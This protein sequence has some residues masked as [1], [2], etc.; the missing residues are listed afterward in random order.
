MGIS[1]EIA[2]IFDLV[3]ACRYVEKMTKTFAL[4]CVFFTWS[5]KNVFV[6]FARLFSVKK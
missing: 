5:G 2:V 1:T 4:M 3:V 6:Q